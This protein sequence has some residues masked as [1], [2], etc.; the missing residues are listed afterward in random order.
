MKSSI[1]NEVAGA[2][3]GQRKKR[4]PSRW[5]LR[6]LIYSSPIL[7]R[8]RSQ[9]NASGSSSKSHRNHIGKSGSN[10]IYALRVS[11]RYFICNFN[12]F[13]SCFITISHLFRSLL[14]IFWSCRNNSHF[15]LLNCHNGVNRTV[16]FSNI[17]DHCNG[18]L[19]ATPTK[20]M[21]FE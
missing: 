18:R 19:W 9:N 6:H 2:C 7:N 4:F 15:H 11:F 20:D 16:R 21:L 10:L 3:G 12:R 5:S 1:E 17:G 13:F 8:R 14:L